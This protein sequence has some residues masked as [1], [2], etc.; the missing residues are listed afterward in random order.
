VVVDAARTTLDTFGVLT[1]RKGQQQATKANAGTVRTMGG[2]VLDVAD[3]N[4]RGA[5]DG[6]DARPRRGGAITKFVLCRASPADQV[7]DQLCFYDEQGE[8]GYPKRTTVELRLRWFM[9]D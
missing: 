2:L 5:K 1:R 4:L 7:N 8:R 9:R 3:A 6:R